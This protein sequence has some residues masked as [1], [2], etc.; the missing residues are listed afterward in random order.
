MH[1]VK[2]YTTCGDGLERLRTETVATPE[3]GP[4]QVLVRMRAVALNYRDLLVIGGHPDWKPPGRRIPGSDGAGVVS[5]LGQG[6]S[7]WAVGDRVIGL[8]LPRWQDGPLT[9]Q[10]YVGALGGPG[11]DGVLAEYVVFDEQALIA[12]PA[13]LSDVEAATLPVAGLT[14]WHALGERARLAPG[15]SVL[16]EGTGG[17]ALFALQFAAAAGAESVVISSSDEKMSEA[18]RLGATMTLNY[19]RNPEWENDVLVA[20]AGR[21]VDVVVEV[22]GGAHLN[23]ALRVVRLGGAICYIGLIAGQRAEIDVWKL[24]TRNVTLHGIE[25]GSRA[26]FERMN[27]FIAAH[28]LRPVVSSVI[29]FDEVGAALE[30]IR[31]GTHLGKVVVEL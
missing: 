30:S 31:S 9:A 7:R 3:P 2:A 18:A 19:R 8:F 26:M 12:S 24:V 15:A 21:G 6:V 29:G 17:V 23:R 1:S 10:T 5:A 22:V 13:Q 11:A 25:T 27:A 14:A 16:I 4:G 20:T 28:R